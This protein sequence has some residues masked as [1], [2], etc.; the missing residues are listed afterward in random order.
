[1]TWTPERIE[2]KLSYLQHSVYGS[3]SPVSQGLAVD[4]LL[5]LKDAL[6][7][8]ERLTAELAQAKLIGAALLEAARKAN[9]ALLIGYND[10]SDYG[11][12]EAIAKAE[13]AAELRER[14]KGAGGA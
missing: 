7:E 9:L 6:A 8:V 2:E 12:A 1:M 10:Y 14:A 11:L 4:L 3:Q 13:R 5:A